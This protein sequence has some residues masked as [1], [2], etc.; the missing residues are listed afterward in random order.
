[1]TAPSELSPRAA[2]I[3]MAIVRTYI[4]T[5]RPVA[6]HTIS[7]R[8]R[9]QLSPATIRNVMA[10]LAE[11]GYLSQPHTSAGRIPTRK[12]FEYFVRTITVKRL[13]AGELERLR[14]ELMRAA[15]VE[16]RVERS[17]QLLAEMT[18][19]MGIAVAIP[20]DSQIL[21]RV[22][23]VDL[24]YGRVLMVVVT[25]DRV[26]RDR[27]V[28]LDEPVTQAELDRIRNYIN[29]HFCGLPLGEIRARIQAHIEQARA[30]YDALL[31]KLLLLYEHG[32]LEFGLAPEVHVEGHW[33]L[34]D[35]E[36]HLTRER[37]RELFATLEEKK[38]LL[39]L[40][41]QFLAGE[42]GQVSVRVGL[43]T[44]H[45]SMQELALIGVAVSLGAGLTA[46]IA[47]LGPMR[48]DYHKAISAVAHLGQALQSTPM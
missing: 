18:Q 20:T 33:S 36:F 31:R 22:E 9:Y 44:I 21:D 6:S 34:L 42:P 19:K 10:D 41:D 8:Q 38:R 43:E 2:E 30:A 15:T 24:G 17:C 16:D 3:L 1:M 11:A 23:L 26:V 14:R 7:R 47:V 32:L 45:P 39:Q 35:I 4:Q 46:K 5:G 29:E 40:L 37:L 48:M 13:L 12:A 27:V 28:I 25:R